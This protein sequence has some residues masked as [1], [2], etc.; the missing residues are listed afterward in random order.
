MIIYNSGL[1][2]QTRK[3]PAKNQVT[4]K[5]KRGKNGVRRSQCRLTLVKKAKGETRFPKNVCSVDAFVYRIEHARTT[6]ITLRMPPKSRVQ[7]VKQ[8]LVSS[9][10]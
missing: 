6:Y 5:G 10:L 3:N 1:F 4:L 8:K 9:S 7:A 2:E